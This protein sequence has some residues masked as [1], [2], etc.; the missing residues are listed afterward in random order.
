MPCNPSLPSTIRGSARLLAIALAA[1][2]LAASAVA[3]PPEFH[4]PVRMKAGDD[5]IRVEKPGYAAPCVADIDRDG[6]PDLLVGQF[7]DGKIRVYK[8]LG[9]GK[10]A[11]GEWLMAGTAVAHVPGVW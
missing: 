11:P 5:L 10:F 8:G 3:A 1:T 9:D 4:P 6:K 7:K 2:P